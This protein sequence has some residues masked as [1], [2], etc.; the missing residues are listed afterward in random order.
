MRIIRKLL[1]NSLAKLSRKPKASVSLK[2]LE[3]FTVDIGAGGEGV[4]AK[5]CGRNTVGIDINKREINEA[6][7][8]G[9]RAQWVLGDA[10][11]MPFRNGSFDAATFFFSLMYIKT[12]KRKLATFIEARRV[13]KS[14]GLLCLWAAIIGEKPGLHALFLEIR[15]PDNGEIFTG[16]GVRGTEK[17]QNLELINKLANKAGFTA[18][19]TEAHKNW[20][21]AYFR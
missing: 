18:T 5:A 7:S 8:R 2:R 6:R 9:S 16:Y 15:L 17:K 4:M 20:I 14:D 12:T 21:E 3:G 19:S 1:M 11:S 10:C 13:L